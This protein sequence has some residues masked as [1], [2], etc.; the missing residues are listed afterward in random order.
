M[1]RSSRPNSKD[2]WTTTTKKNKKLTPSKRKQA[3]N[4]SKNPATFPSNLIDYTYNPLQVS[5]VNT[6]IAHPLP[7]LPHL[8]R[9]QNPYLP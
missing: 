3:I 4:K 9:D 6:I 8:P 5:P 1:R 2:L 7:I